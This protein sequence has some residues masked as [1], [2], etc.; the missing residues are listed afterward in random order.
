MSEETGD[1]PPRPGQSYISADL[2][3]LGDRRY[4]SG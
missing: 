1:F 4:R 2:N 3:S